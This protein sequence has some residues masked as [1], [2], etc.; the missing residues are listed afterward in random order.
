MMFIEII[1]NMQQSMELK[2]VPGLTSKN[3]HPGQYA[4]MRVGNS[5]KVFSHR[6][7]S[8]VQ[9]LA[10]DGV[11]DN[12]AASTAWFCDSTNRWF[13]LMAN[14]AFKT[15]LFNAS[16]VTAE[17]IQHLDEYIDLMSHMEVCGKNSVANAWKPWQKGVLLSTRSVREMYDE[18]VVNG[19]LSFLVTGRLT[20]DALENLFS[21]IRG[22][23][24][25]H[26]STVHFR[27]CLKLITTSQFM[28][29]PKSS[30][31]NE[32]N[33]PNL[34]DCLKNVTPLQTDLSPDVPHDAASELDYV[35][36][37]P[38]EEKV[39]YDLAGWVGHAIKSSVNG[40]YVCLPLL[41]DASPSLPQSSF[42]TV[43]S[44]GRLNHPSQ[45]LLTLI[46]EAE[47]F[48]RNTNVINRSIEELST[49]MIKKCKQDLGNCQNHNLLEMA[50]K[51]FYSLRIHVRASFITEQLG[52]KKQYA[53]KSAA[54]RTT[55]E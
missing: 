25:D 13:D 15:A 16:E 53:S 44:Y 39:L 29:V 22:C 17:H 3:I 26:P 49:S 37:G 34:I 28:I 35:K 47:L 9:N 20:Q 7:A 2:L 38:E 19:Q 12:D 43:R 40:C 8:A 14:R 6:T 11:L 51:Q 50:V 23:G 18:L 36:P 54:A 30:S 52:L 21:Q 31:Y 5:T 24:D 48:F 27:Q 46:R 45:S 33:V 55:I 1:V 10:E 41:S 42:T 32:D 4:K